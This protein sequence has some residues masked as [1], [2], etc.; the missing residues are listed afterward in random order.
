MTKSKTSAADTP[1]KKLTLEWRAGEDH[2]AL[3]F[4][5]ETWITFESVAQ[6]K[7]TTA[8]EMIIRAVVHTLGAVVFDGTSSETG[9]A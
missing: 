5:R 4:A 7:G 9:H 3:L 1:K 2:V 6:D 8:Q